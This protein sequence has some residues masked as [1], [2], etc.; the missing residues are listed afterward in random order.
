MG[1][2]GDLFPGIEVPRQRD[3]DLEKKIEECF[4]DIGLQPEENAVLKTVQLMELLAVRHCVFIMG[5]SGTGKSTCWKILGAA[6]GKRGQK[7]TV[8]DLDPK[9]IT[10]TE[11]YGYINM[12]TREWKDGI[13]SLLL[14]E[15]ANAPGTDPKWIILDGDLDANWI[16]SMN[17]V[18]DDNKLLTLASNERI[19]MKPH[20]RLIFELRD[21][22]YATPATSSRA[23]VLY[24]TES[25]QW[26]N[27]VQTWVMLRED[28]SPER[29]SILLELY[30]TYIPDT[31]F[32]LTKEFR[33]MVPIL[34][35]NMVQTLTRVLEGLLTNEN[36]PKGMANE[37]IILETYFVF[38]CIWSFGS[39]FSISDGVDMRK[40]Y[41]TWWKQKWTR[42]K[43]PTK[44]SVFDF[45][46]DKATLKFTPWA[47]IVPSVSYESTTPMDSV[48]VPTGETQSVTFFLDLL[49]ELRFPAILVGLAGAGKTA[50]INGKLRGL[51]EDFTTL[52]IN[53]NYYTD[54]AGFRSNLESPLEKKAGRNYGPPGNLRLV[55]FVDD[56][57]MPQLDPYE[58]QYPIS[59]LRQY[60]DYQHWYDMT[61]LQL[62]VIQNV[63]FLCSMNPTCGSFVVNPRLQRHFM[64]FAIGFPGAEALMTIFSTFL[65][66][67]LKNFEAALSDEQFAHKLIQAALELHNKVAST[68]RKTA[69]NF[70]YEFSIR[71]L[72]SVFKG[73]LMSEPTYFQDPS[74]YA[75]LFIHEAERVYGDRLVSRKD[76]ETYTKIAK[77]NMFKF[78]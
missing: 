51:P 36:V 2:L 10:T 29:K 28:D 20:M 63:Q 12:T 78:N 71:H 1:L 13:F 16:E 44:G 49:V 35:F 70:H 15:A 56:L 46:V 53:F 22:K 59:L 67:H 73:L 25:K 19:V 23:G 68:F 17:S 50:L 52:T 8:K 3:W 38:A 6:N 72:A 55:Y 39:G 9:A 42:I 5:T 75:S 65:K 37:A 32:A 43:M 27:F 33:H 14:R 62:R 34:D 41:S 76:L 21:L 24:I 74:K 48:T 47:Q 58:T 61:K 45:F 54:G 40:N 26:W 18:M 66:G 31:L 30:K 60:M 4:V 57:N 64:T 77:V 69:I 11:F 7:T